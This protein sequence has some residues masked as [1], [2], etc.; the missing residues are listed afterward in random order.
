[1]KRSSLKYNLQ[2]IYRNKRFTWLGQVL[3]EW[4]VAQ[5]RELNVAKHS[6]SPIDNRQK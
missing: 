1:M 6:Y 3:L 4:K 2:L 5:K